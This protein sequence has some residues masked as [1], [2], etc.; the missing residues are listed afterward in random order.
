VF[1]LPAEQLT[2]LLRSC[3]GSTPNPWERLL[4]DWDD[5]LAQDSAAAAL[6]EVWLQELTAAVIK[7]AAP[8]KVW[9]MLGAEHGGDWSP[10]KVLKHLSQPTTEVFGAN[11]A[12]ERDRLL[13]DTL[14]SAG[15]KL[16][17]LEGPDTAAWSWGKLHVVR[18]RHPLEQ[19]PGA[20]EIMDLGPTPRPGDEYTVNATGFLGGSFAQISGASYREILDT[21]N[22]DRSIA[23]NTPGQSGQP[24]SQHYADL[25]PLW[26]DGKY[27]PLLYSKD[28]VEKHATDKLVLEPK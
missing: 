9:K 11:P 7:R 22:W 1:S 26:R 3:V 23:V 16:Q 24:E 8:E 15:R 18:F 25:L 13:R 6:Y 27:F 12:A 21:S 28:A 4:L 10:A 20:A 2:D 5:V 19:L 14:D 17:R